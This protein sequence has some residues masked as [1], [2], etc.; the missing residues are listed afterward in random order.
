[1][2]CIFHFQKRNQAKAAKILYKTI[3]LFILANILA[4][5][6]THIGSQFGENVLFATLLERNE[7]QQERDLALR[8]Y[9]ITMSIV[10]SV[11]R[12]IVH[13]RNRF[14]KSDWLYLKQECGHQH[15]TNHCVISVQRKIYIIH[16]LLLIP[17]ANTSMHFEIHE[18][19]ERVLNNKMEK[20]MKLR[21]LSLFYRLPQIR[22]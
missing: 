3:I 5:S 19:A 10:Q 1:M 11:L 17:K 6:M 15:N 12:N 22:S 18:T 21:V 9:H 2:K 20:S 16:V 8:F 14:E 7:Q 4:F 13:S